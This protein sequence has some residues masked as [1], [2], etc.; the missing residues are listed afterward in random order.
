[1]VAMAICIT[2]GSGEVSFSKERDVVVDMNLPKKVW[3]GDKSFSLGKKLLSR[4]LPEIENPRLMSLSDLSSFEIPMFVE[5]GDVFVLRGD[6][7]NDGIADVAF[8]GKGDNIGDDSFFV[9]VSIK[10]GKIRREYF[11]V[12]DAEKI[13][14]NQ[15]SYY[16]GRKSI[17]LI[18][19]Y[20]SEDTSFIYWDGKQY[21]VAKITENKN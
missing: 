16:K 20:G 8:V 19:T 2:I 12:I 14:L 11:D 3:P 18:F 17:M 7:N 10:N 1:M 15:Q 13:T 4:L 9:I 21:K 6:F 5:E